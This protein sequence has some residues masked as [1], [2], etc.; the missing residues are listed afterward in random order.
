MLDPS[1]RRE[2]LVLFD[3]PSSRASI[4]T[5]LVGDMEV[6]RQR[7]DGSLS[8]LT[9]VLPLQGL[10]LEEPALRRSLSATKIRSTI[11]RG[12]GSSETVIGISST[13]GSSSAVN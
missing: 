4:R 11:S 6:E 5:P 7:I 1:Q 13:P 8:V 12:R 2:R 3:D 10:A 9:Y